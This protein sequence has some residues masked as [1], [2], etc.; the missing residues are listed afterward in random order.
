M[1]GLTTCQGNSHRCVPRLVAFH[2]RNSVWWKSESVKVD[3]LYCNSNNISIKRITFAA[4]VELL[5][6]GLGPFCQPRKVMQVCGCVPPAANADSAIGVLHELKSGAQTLFAL[7]F[8]VLYMNCLFL[9]LFQ[10]VGVYF[11][12]SDH[13]VN[14][15]NFHVFIYLDQ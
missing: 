4:D 6:V 12:I 1:C 7:Y 15:T 3:T 2:R 10:F 8:N 11:K 13:F 5:C 14:K 9:I